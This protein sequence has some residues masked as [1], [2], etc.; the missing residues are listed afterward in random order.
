MNKKIFLTAMVL[1]VFAGC[2]GTLAQPDIS[3]TYP[4]VKHSPMMENAISIFMFIENKGDGDDYLVSARIK[5]MPDKKVEIHDVV[6]G[7][8]VAIE[9]IK[10]PAGGVV[11]LKMGSYHIMGFGITEHLDEIT[12]VLNFGKSGEI[13]VAAT[14]PEKESAEMEG[15]EMEA[16]E[17]GEMGDM[18]GM[19]M[20]GGYGA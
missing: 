18:E 3:V 8:M 2:A 20:G 12:V 4:K 14:V 9:K 17:T 10:I 7:K 6:N 1:S 13:E 15:M 19:E 11:E 5:E 16:E